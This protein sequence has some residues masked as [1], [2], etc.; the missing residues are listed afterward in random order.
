MTYSD[1]FL[2]ELKSEAAKTRK[3]LEVIPLEQKDY[4]PHEK[5]MTLGALAGHI[6]EAPKAMA[7]T[8]NN[9]VYDFQTEGFKPFIP[10]TKEELLV[11]FD[12]H[13][14]EA[15]KSLENR[16]DEDFTKNWTF[17]VNG[18]EIFSLPKNVIIRDLV[19]NHSIHHRGQMA[20]YLRMLNIPL[21]NIYG[22]SAD[23]N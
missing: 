14:K 8:M 12:D 22:P 6:A 13:M 23:T 10:L 18:K 21:P 20:V 17:L 7:M 5:S 9:D 3:I 15:E 4:K 16:T 2:A 1:F 11:F 19:F